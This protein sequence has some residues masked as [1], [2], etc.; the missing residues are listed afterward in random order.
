MYDQLIFSFYIYLFSEMRQN[1]WKEE[2]ERAAYR[3]DFRMKNGEDSVEFS[4]FLPQ[5][6][7]FLSFHLRSSLS[8]AFRAS[9]S[10]RASAFPYH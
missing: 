4:P 10:P 6:S 2:G 8:S 3:A 7:D 5:I 9:V 1:H